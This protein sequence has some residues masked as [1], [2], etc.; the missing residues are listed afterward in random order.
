MK[1]VARVLRTRPLVSYFR[2]IV[3]HN[4]TNACARF[5]IFRFRIIGYLP[6]ALWS[7]PHAVVPWRPIIFANYAPRAAPLALRFLKRIFFFFAGLSRCKLTR[8]S[9]AKQFRGKQV[10]FSPER[11]ILFLFSG[12]PCN[13]FASRNWGIGSNDD[14]PQRE[15]QVY[16]KPVFGFISPG[17]YNILIKT[18]FKRIVIFFILSVAQFHHSSNLSSYRM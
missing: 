6:K 7:T 1:A 10:N 16:F 14:E 8:L 18:R 13:G 12:Q 2:S 4:T 5:W 3:P 15:Q 11:S 9:N 17:S